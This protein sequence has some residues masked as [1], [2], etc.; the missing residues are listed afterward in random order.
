MRF[1]SIFLATVFLS[2]HYGA[3]LYVNSSLLST[4]F[5]PN[6]VSL[7]FLGGAVGNIIFFLFAPK[8]IRLFGKRSFLLLSLILVAGSTLFMAFSTNALVVAVFS[9]VYFSLILIT[10]YCLD[11]FIEELSTNQRTGE[12]R[13]LYLTFISLGVLLGPLIMAFLSTMDG[14]FKSIYITATAL[15][16]PP[17][18]LALFSF[19]SHAPKA[20]GHYHHSLALPFGAWWR[21]KNIRRITL[22]RLIL[23][24]F[25]SLMVIYTPL[26]LHSILGFEWSELGIIFTVMLLPFVLLEWPAGELA[27][28]FWGEKEIMS[29][30]F[31]ITGA[32]LLVMPLLGKVFLAWMTILFLS[33]VGAS[34][35][36]TMTESYFFK[37]VEANDTGL[38]SI[39]RLTRPV[40]N[41]FGIIVGFLS[42]N[43]FSFNKIFFVA[44]IVVFFGL[45]ESWYLK[46]T[47]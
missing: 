24:S 34:L 44:A 11:I 22:A 33:R 13:G 42:I 23:E 26:Y 7:M 47:R 28:R 6:I 20:H 1:V 45:K 39:F 36:E 27:D 14:G 15:L 38:L 8:L 32:S 10:Y 12:I 40:G 41:I 35:V 17:I 25:V 5:E 21:A 31:L 37:H 30:G 18:L 46:D 2:I 9:I 19:Q 16:I 4:Y 43:L 29:I 3:I